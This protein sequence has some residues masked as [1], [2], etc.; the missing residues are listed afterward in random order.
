MTPSGRP[1]ADAPF[2]LV[3]I[4]D[5]LIHGQ[6]T[7]AWGTWLEPDRIVLAND[8]VARTPWRRDLYAGSDTLG[9]A[10]SIVTVVELADAAR[11]QRWSDERVIAVLE[12]PTDLLRALDAGVRVP[13]AN[14]GGMHFS[15]GK[16]EL[17]PYVYVD[18]G[19]VR[20]LE[21]VAAR[22]TVLMAQDVPQS[23]PID[24]ME[25]IEALGPAG[26]KDTDPRE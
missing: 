4:D 11:D 16:R 5:R 3:R 23:T 21:A 15:P 10:V 7:V 26:G 18:D 2:L 22:G 19:D 24:L 25:L 1:D 17:L 6:V 12:S 8:E 20:A 13:E 14:V 9:A